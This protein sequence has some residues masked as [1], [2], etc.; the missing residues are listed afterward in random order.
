MI[1]EEYQIVSFDLEALTANVLV[2]QNGRP[3][4]VH[5]V[6]LIGAKLIKVPTEA[7]EVKP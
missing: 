3:M 4:A 1:S 7:T 2:L 5:V 6:P